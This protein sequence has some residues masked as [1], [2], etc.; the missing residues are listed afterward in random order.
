MIEKGKFYITTSIAYT[1]AP[2]HLGY[3]LE[4]VQA[5]VLARHAHQQG[6]DVWFLTGT[7]EHGLKIVQ[8]ARAAGQAPHAFVDVLAEKFRALKA[9]YNLANDDFIRTTDSERHW[10]GAVK[11]WQ[12]LVEA[13]DIYKATY[14]GLYCIG[15]EAFLTEHELDGEGYCPTH[16]TRPE[17]VEEENYFF[18]LSKYQSEL[19][20]LIESDELAVVPEARAHEMMSLIEEGLK[21]VSFSR[22]REVLDWG[23]PVPGDTTQTMYVWCDALANYLTA[24]G[25]AN[26]TEQ[27]KTFWPADV[28]LVGKDILR[29]H[30]LMWP[31]ML[32][33]AK[34]ALPRRILV[35]GFITV[36]GGKMSK[37]LGNVV[38]PFQLAAAFGA[39]PIRYYLLRE[40]PSSGDGD[41]S[42]KRLLERYDSDLAKGLGNLVSRVLTV[43]VTEPKLAGIAPER[44]TVE[45]LAKVHADYSAAVES[46]ELHRALA[47]IW[48]LMS[49][50]DELVERER[51]W[52]LNTKDPERFRKVMLQLLAGLAKVGQMLWPFM[53]DTAEVVLAFLGGLKRDWVT[54]G[55][56][57]HPPRALF[58][59]LGPQVAPSADGRGRAKRPEP[60]AP[61]H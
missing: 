11:L 39:D 30:A 36:E 6:K 15:H 54:E 45:A 3:A 8:A 20:R 12:K 60:D 33:A 13:G 17:V 16:K 50:L 19:K 29:F 49:D 14:R 44:S 7:D 24:V 4:S 53:P 35:H 31:A 56:E 23:I 28:H 21:D 41:F 1:N 10:P 37:S 42:Q 55:F 43:A 51:I 26:E 27:F 18:R 38:D 9:A 58:P 57:P 59:R 61:P 52:E 46:F 48:K 22:P 32:L 5:D 34:L 2:P 47:V 40:L 25:Y